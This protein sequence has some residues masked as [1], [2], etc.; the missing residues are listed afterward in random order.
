MFIGHFAIAYI[1]IHFFPGISPL[2]PLA[3][4]SFP[5]IL[6]PFLILSGIEKVRINPDSPLQKNI[7]FSSYPYS[8]SLLIS[9]LIALIAGIGI[10]IW[11]SPLAGLIFVVC[12]ASHWVLDTIVHQRD[13]PV[14]GVSHD[15]KEGF[16]LW[17]YPKSAFVIEYVFYVVVTLAVM[18]LVPAIGLILIG[19]VFHLINANSFFGFTK[20][21][22]FRT[23]RSYALLTLVGFVAFIILAYM[24]IS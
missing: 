14:F 19:S 22:P 15:I 7:I 23:A 2:V 3:G 16:G 10:G 8:H 1:F 21:N 12:S 24:V 13:L 4:V 9:T 6:W 20:T 17:N 5:D 18:P 11:L